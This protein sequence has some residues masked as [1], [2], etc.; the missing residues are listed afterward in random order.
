MT[1]DHVNGYDG[2]LY[3]RTASKEYPF[4]LDGFHRVLADESIVPLRRDPW[5]RV[6]KRFAMSFNGDGAFKDRESP[7]EMSVR[8]YEQWESESALPPGLTLAEL[9]AILYAEARFYGHRGDGPYDG[10]EREFVDVLLDAIRAAATRDRSLDPVPPSEGELLAQWVLELARG[11]R[12]DSRLSTPLLEL[13]AQNVREIIEDLDSE[14]ALPDRNP[15]VPW[16][17]IVDNGVLQFA[18]YEA[19][20]HAHSEPWPVVPD[21]TRRPRAEDIV[22]I[23]NLSDLI[24]TWLPFVVEVPTWA[25]APG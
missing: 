23:Y 19:P 20:E 24:E 22:E 12:R 2:P 16:Q 17:V 10:L 4:L 25:T 13:Q 9:R 11:F 8:V 21:S 7:V 18:E 3:R 15:D 5:D 1:P 6:V 14:Y